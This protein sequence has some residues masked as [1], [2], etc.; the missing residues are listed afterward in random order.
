[1]AF[2]AVVFWLAR[3]VLMP[4]VVAAII[5]YAFSPYI[6]AVQARTGRS[7]FL[8]VVILYGTG[9]CSSSRRSSSPSRAR[10]SARSQ[11]LIRAGPDA[12]ETALR[13]VLGGDSITIGDRTITV[14]ELAAQAE[15]ALTAFLQ[16]PGG[17][18]PGGRR[19]SSTGR[20]T[21][22]SCSS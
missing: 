8:I 13:Q 12:V 10:C 22:S 2:V 18:D 1:M 3:P 5:A 6:D 16:T 4:F 15:A 19:R 7:R 14:E 11:L 17:R 9:V 20:S 21:P